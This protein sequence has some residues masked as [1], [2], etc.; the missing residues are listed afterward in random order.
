MPEY[1]APRTGQHDIPAVAWGDEQ[2]LPYPTSIWSRLQFGHFIWH[3][4]LSLSIFL[5]LFILISTHCPPH[6]HP[7]NL[8]GSMGGLGPS[9][10][11]EDQQLQ[12]ALQALGRFCLTTG[13][14]ASPGTPPAAW[15]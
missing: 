7:L 4:F 2:G 12:A 10:G 15:E 3:G 8:G 11:K 6:S 13:D 1:R 14:R 5:M 9:W